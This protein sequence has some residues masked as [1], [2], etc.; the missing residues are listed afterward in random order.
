MPK[1]IATRPMWQSAPPKCLHCNEPVEDVLDAITWRGGYVHRSCRLP[2]VVDETC[3]TAPP[4]FVDRQLDKAM[5]ALRAIANYNTL[6][7]DGWDAVHVRNM[8]EKAIK[9]LE[10][11]EE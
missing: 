8:A 9:E 2:D 7:S 10:G 5:D 3:S 4:S 11:E 1:S 6:G